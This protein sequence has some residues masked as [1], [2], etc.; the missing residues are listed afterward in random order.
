M[1][2]FF[3]YLL[4]HVTFNVKYLFYWY[5][6]FCLLL[7]FIALI[8]LISF[9]LN[10]KTGYDYSWL[11]NKWGVVRG[12]LVGIRLNSIISEPT[13][14]AS[15]LSPALYVSLSNI[16]SKKNI[17]LN[18]YESSLIIIVVILTT[19]TIGYLGLLFSL[20]FVTKTIRLR[21]II[22][23]FF[24]SIISFNIAYKYANEF[25]I[26]VDA[27]KGLWLDNN[28]HI[29]NTNTSS[30]VLFNN[31][32]VAKE[33]LSTFPIFGTGLGSHETAFKKHTL[34][35]TIIS[36]D[37]E[38][39]VKDGNSLFVRLCTETGLIGLFSVLFLI[40]KGFIYRS[41]YQNEDLYINVVI[42]Q[43]I[44]ILFVLVLIRQGNYMLNG[45]PLLFLIYY[46]NFREYNKKIESLEK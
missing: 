12:G 14:L 11:L 22:F 16:V 39:N 26:R 21:F 37:F 9:S 4:N 27:A 3:Y 15:I 30:F 41:K 7:S 25:K 35:K 43:S 18:K 45:L 34:T 1:I 8:Q 17:I 29:S 23:G 38:F 33:N 5:C 42:S 13:Y 24:L 31:L 28:F 44:F 46:Y 19:S 32:H 2:L 40:F 20:L 10:F 6:R 36:Y